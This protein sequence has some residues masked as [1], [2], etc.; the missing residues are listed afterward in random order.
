MNRLVTLLL[1][2]T[3]SLSAQ[4]IR[5]RP[6]PYTVTQSDGTTLTVIKHGNDHLAYYT[7]LDGKVLQRNASGDLCYARL[8][9]SRLQP[10]SYIAHNAAQ[11]AATEQAFAR[12]SALTP[13]QV[14]AI[15]AETSPR[16][17]KAI[18][19]STSDGLGKY[20]TSGKGAVGSIGAYTIPVIMVQF[21]DLK[22]QSSTTV[23]KMNRFYNEVGYDD[24]SSCVG[25]VRD[26]FVS[27]SGG[28]FTPTF[29]IVGIVTL[30]TSYKTYGA[31][32]SY[33][34]DKGWDNYAFLRACVNA[35]AAQ[36]VDFAQY[37]QGSGVPLVALLYAGPGEAT[38]Y[39]S[40]AEN[41]LW[42]AE[43][44]CDIDI[45][46]VHFNSVFMGNELYYD[47]SLMGMGVFCHEFGHA[48]GLPD[49]YCTDYSYEADD[50]F[51]FWDIMDC[52]AYVNS[53]RAPIGYTAYERSYL[54][55][56]N[57]VE[58]GSEAQKVTLSKFDAASAE[59]GTNAVIIR[60]SR[61]ET[62][63][64]E[65]RQ[66]G[67]WYPSSFGSGIML[68]RY[69]YSQSAW[70]QNIPN[71]TQS[72]KRACLLPANNVK[73]NYGTNVS[74]RN[75][76]GNGV[77]EI[78]S[79]P[80]YSG[81]AKTDAPI[82]NITKSGSD[83]TFYWLST[84][85]SPY[86]VGDT[87]EQ[88]GLTSRYVGNLQLL[89]EPK[90]D[91]AYTGEVQIPATF[92]RDGITYTY[93]GIDSLAFAGCDGLTAVSI[94]ATVTRIAT[95]A[96]RHTP[97]LKQITV[98]ADNEA[99]QSVGGVLFT[100]STLLDGVSASAA[101]PRAA[102][103]EQTATFD[104]GGNALGLPVSTSASPSAGNI[105]APLTVDDV[106]LST[107][108][109][110]T[111]TRLWKSTSTTDLRV[112]KNGGTLTFSVPAQQE[113]TQIVFTYSALNMTASEGTLTSG[114]WTGTAQSV[115]FSAGATC[116][117]TKVV[118]TY[119]AAA[120]AE[121][122]LLCYP[123][124][125]G[126]D[127][128]VPKAVSRLADYAFED[129]DVRTLVLS[130]SLLTL[131]ANA[132]STAALTSLACPAMTPPTAESDPFTAV[133]KS[134]CTLTVPAEAEAAYRAADY[135]KEFFSST[136]IATPTAPVASDSRTPLFDLSGR[137][138]SR[139]T[140]GVYIMGGRKVVVP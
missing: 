90:A 61:S 114:T 88:A 62:F 65:N 53:S 131:G 111:A 18:Q 107:T 26:Y 67:T 60:N 82:Y 91:G 56:Q 76:Y 109:G 125:L 17:R 78:T 80:T 36:G 132:L 140:R 46:G 7:T 133:N 120:P 13:T 45:N 108:D 25:S 33:G 27:Q 119:S 39:S 49:F 35:A 115:T 4:A 121:A 2:G 24:E 9:G 34:N 87:L 55:W 86:S 64:L 95:D 103:T 14:A 123:A 94:P 83:I 130:D 73:F 113:I 118:V 12:D 68:Q 100:R 48:L 37:V 127:Y 112:Y 92:T 15:K 98:A 5:P 137:R 89:V 40:N 129:A 135:W 51:G 47:N 72:K 30:N 63:I 101:R 136:N 52:G 74:P 138:I 79:L 1:A 105:T 97:A 104:F 106:T 38:D 58:L 23:D 66:P 43:D 41:Y 22:F 21:S 126:T 19:A 31:N 99:F 20:G 16:N 93:I 54:G 84:D 32:D 81:T 128:T 11:R 44:D 134:L 96:F 3:L 71:N 57:L 110:T 77:N 6:V 42:P 69:A 117:I 124:A 70:S 116:K 139:T 59:A 85:I 102:T 75:L 29:E 50:P 122:A 8:D 28:M 10:T